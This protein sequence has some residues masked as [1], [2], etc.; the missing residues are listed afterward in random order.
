MSCHCSPRPPI[1]HRPQ[2]PTQR[3]VIARNTRAWAGNL[4][5]STHQHVRAIEPHSLP[6]CTSDIII[7][8]FARRGRNRQRLRSVLYLCINYSHPTLFCYTWVSC[9]RV[10]FRSGVTIPHTPGFLTHFTSFRATTSLVATLRGRL[11]TLRMSAYCRAHR[12]ASSSMQCPAPFAQTAATPELRRHCYPPLAFSL[13]FALPMAFAISLDWSQFINP[14]LPLGR[15][16]S[17]VFPPPHT[18]YLPTPYSRTD[19][20]TPTHP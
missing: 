6:S 7:L 1:T 18:P 9:P 5:P 17:S 12:L 19:S 8:T 3:A 14:L 20:A 4:F 11:S 16:F 15:H 10:R 2:T 13:V